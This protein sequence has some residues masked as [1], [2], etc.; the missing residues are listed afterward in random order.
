MK[1]TNK[2]KPNAILLKELQRQT[3]KYSSE[4]M[5]IG[6]VLLHYDT[7]WFL[8]LIRT[9]GQESFLWKCKLS[10]I[11]PKNQNIHVVDS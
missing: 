11:A 4:E 6:I 5:F 3:M 10:L 7:S 1:G 9:W 2:V 8:L